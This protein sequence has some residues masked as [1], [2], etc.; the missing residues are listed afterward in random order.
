[1]YFVTFDITFDTQHF[2]HHNCEKG[3]KYKIYIISYEISVRYL[4]VNNKNLIKH[5]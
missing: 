3:Y 1:M 4:I 2:Y 5:I